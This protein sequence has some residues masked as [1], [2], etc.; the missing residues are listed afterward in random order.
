MDAFLTHAAEIL[1][2][3]QNCCEAG[4]VPSDLAI[5]IGRSGEIRIV[6]GTDWPLESLR[7]ERGAAMA[8]R[9]AGAGGRV[10][11]EGRMPG[12][13]CLL[14][15]ESPAAVWRRLLPTAPAPLPALAAA[16]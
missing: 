9:V 7:R 11:V 12:R 1:D 3:A 14:E 5:L 4:G 6:A 8:F 15:S 16:R 2:A 13:G 10:A